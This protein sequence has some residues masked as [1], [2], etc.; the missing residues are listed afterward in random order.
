MPRKITPT[1]ETAIRDFQ[2]V[3][4]TQVG[5]HALYNDGVILNQL[6]RAVGPDIQ[7]HRALTSSAV[8]RYM[9]EEKKRLN[10]A[11]FNKVRSR[12]GGFF[13]FCRQR[14]W[15]AQ[16]PLA[17]IGRANTVRAERIRLSPTELLALPRY[18]KIPRDK[19]LIIAASNTALRSGELCRLRIKDVDLE[20]GYLRVD[21]TKS[22]LRDQMPITEELDAALREWLIVYADD[23]GP[24]QPDWLLFPRYKVGAGRRTATGQFIGGSPVDR[25]GSYLPTQPVRHTARIVQTAM[26]ESGLVVEKGEGMHTLRRSAA[27]AYF[28]WRVA[29]GYDGALRECAAWLHHKHVSTTEDYLGISSEKLQRDR[30][31]RG[32]PFLGSMTSAD[33]VVPLRAAGGE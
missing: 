20:Q 32:N 1:V 22:N 15:I 11:S 16:D 23:A 7:V 17:F 30:A 4:T 27:R 29:S 6:A 18:A 26:E 14:D 28:D 12:L 8:E 33:E 5:E 3:R 24:L 19:A 13:R 2:E 25:V 10:G 9:V 21:I 31:L